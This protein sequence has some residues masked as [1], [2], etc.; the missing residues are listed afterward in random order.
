MCWKCH[1][2]AAEFCFQERALTHHA[3]MYKDN[4]NLLILNLNNLARDLYGQISDLLKLY[5][6]PRNEEVRTIIVPY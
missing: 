3:H 6:K 4:R 2:S 1:K 5:P